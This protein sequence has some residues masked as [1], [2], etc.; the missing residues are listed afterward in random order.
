LEPRSIQLDDG[1]GSK[2]EAFCDTP[3]GF[4]GTSFELLDGQ[5][6]CTAVAM[7][8]AGLRTSDN[9]RK[10]TGRF[11]ADLR[12]EADERWVIFKKEKQVTDESLQ[13]TFAALAAGYLP[14]AVDPDENNK[15]DF[16]K[17]WSPYLEMIADDG[18]YDGDGP[19]TEE[20]DYRKNRL[21]ELMSAIG[22][23]QLATYTVDSSYDLAD[24]CEIFETLNETGT[25][26]STVDLIHSFV[27]QESSDKDP[28]NPM[29][30]RG[31]IDE[32]GTLSGAEGWSSKDQDPERVAQA[33]TAAYVGLESQPTA[34]RLGRDKEIK[35]VRSIKGPD[36]LR[37]PTVHWLGVRERQDLFAGTFGLFQEY[38]A[39][40]RFP[41]AWCP[42]VPGSIAV[43]FGLAWP[44]QVEDIEAK[45][46]WS[47]DDLKVL[48]PSF[49]WRN[50]LS[51]RYDQGFLTQ[52]ATDMETLRQLLRLRKDFESQ[53]QWLEEIV[54]PLDSIFSEVSLPDTDELAK[55]A[56][57]GV[58]GARRDAILLAI[59]TRLQ[60]DLV[61]QEA[62]DYPT[63]TNIETHHIWPSKWVKK[64][65]TGDLKTLLDEASDNG[66]NP[67]ESPAN[68]IPLSS[69]SNSKWKDK[70][71]GQ[72]LT[73]TYSATT[74]DLFDAAVIDQDSYDL[75]IGGNPDSVREFLDIRSQSIAYYLESLMALSV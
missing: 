8:F 50:A 9:R 15:W 43:F 21:T 72:A 54:T 23:V 28:D 3:S 11:F 58:G 31:W 71:P 46:G 51:G 61:T 44:H 48:F 22:G 14:L 38:V 5:Q 45:E 19:S 36:L 74:K 33:V 7:A 25:K 30:L 69:A 68:K 12:S 13:N 63:F 59:R 73:V 34:R 10:T 2:Y 65:T 52:S 47:L 35:E 53:A 37:T 29:A 41:R 20:R 75:L 40:V 42:Y 67:I 66:G 60:K 56:K 24:I 49:F 18:F 70:N 32:L 17:A 16:T 1:G 57:A 26:V 55:W 62:I 4:P 6:R 39:G 64:N 27:L